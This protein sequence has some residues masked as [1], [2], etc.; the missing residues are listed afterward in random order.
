MLDQTD[1]Q[2]LKELTKNCR[3]KINHLAQ[4]VH[5]T[6]PAVTARIKRLED[7]GIIKRYTIEV[8]TEKLGYDRQIFIRAA[9]KDAQQRAEYSALIKRYRN[10]IRHHYR[11]T[12]DMPYLIEGAF[13]SRAEL[14]DFLLELGTVATYKVSDVIDQLI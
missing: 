11:V 1:T 12:G 14:N 7:T 10:A 4:H 3:I 13:H 5:L 8:D 6:A 2:I 9:M